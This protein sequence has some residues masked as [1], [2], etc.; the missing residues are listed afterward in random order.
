MCNFPIRFV[1]LSLILV[2]SGCKP[3]AERLKEKQAEE[4]ANAAVTPSP[5]PMPDQV[6]KTGVGVKGDSLNEIKGND[7][8]MLIAGPVKAYFNL[9]ERTVF[10]IN[11]PKAEQ[12]YNAL[13]GRNPRNHEEYMRE[14]VKA[15]NIQLPRLP[16]GMVYRYHPDT[17]ELWVEAEKKQ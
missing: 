6:A 7:P 10:E 9:R 5:P 11:L 2:S 14:I 15:N 13:H 12:L 17:N 16:E 4:A 3:E 8:R 1:L